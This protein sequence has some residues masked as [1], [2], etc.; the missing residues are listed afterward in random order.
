MWHGFMG[1]LNYTYSHAL[2][3]VSNGGVLPYQITASQTSILT[4]I[5]PNCLRCQNYSNADYDLRHK[6]DRQLS[7]S[8]AVPQRKSIG[9]CGAWRLDCVRHSIFPYRIPVQLGRMPVISTQLAE[10]W[11]RR[12]IIGAADH[13]GANS[14]TSPGVPCYSLAQF[15]GQPKTP[16]LIRPCNS[17]SI[18]R[19]LGSERSN[20][21]LTVGRII[22][23]PTSAF[24]RTSV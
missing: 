23:T 7:V 10:Q 11:S 19:R 15:A 4:Q 3:D 1:R 14:C 12:D 22:S 6:S 9:G 20:G 17:S 13:A 18:R 2:D 8:N 24:G 16:V 5:N 21:T